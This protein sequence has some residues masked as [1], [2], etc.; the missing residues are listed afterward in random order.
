MK[1]PYLLTHFE[2]CNKGFWSRDWERLALDGI[3]MLQKAVAAGAQSRSGLI[4]ERL[5]ARR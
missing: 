1:S 5:A 4:S 2:T 3:E